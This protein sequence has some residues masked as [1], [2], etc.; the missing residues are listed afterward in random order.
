MWRYVLPG[1]MICLIQRKSL[2]IPGL[3]MADEMNSFQS[4]ILGFTKFGTFGSDS[5]PDCTNKEDPSG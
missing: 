1:C 5:L 3:S 4:Y 2:E